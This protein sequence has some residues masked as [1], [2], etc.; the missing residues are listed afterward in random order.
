MRLSKNYVSNPDFD[1]LSQQLETLNCCTD[2]I[3]K[4]ANIETWK[5]TKSSSI[6]HVSYKLDDKEMFTRHLVALL[7]LITI[8]HVKSEASARTDPPPRALGAACE[9]RCCWEIG[10]GREDCTGRYYEFVLRPTECGA[11]CTDKECNER[12]GK[13]CEMPKLRARLHST[14]RRGLPRALALLC[15]LSAA[16]ALLFFAFIRQPPQPPHTFDIANDELTRRDSETPTYGSLNNSD[17][18]K[19]SQ[20]LP[21]LI[22][23]P[24]ESNISIDNT[25]PLV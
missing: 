24:P 25:A 19:L 8:T 6:S 2:G 23:K 16:I 14:C 3:T 4:H 17:Q 5:Q 12:F 18:P 20:D 15:F 11:Q 13:H 7:L 21:F 10:G 22:P 1:L 9:C